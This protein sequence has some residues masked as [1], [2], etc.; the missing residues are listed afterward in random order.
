MRGEV[1]MGPP[2]S[3]SHHGWTY[4]AEGRSPVSSP[5]SACPSRQDMSSTHSHSYTRR[6]KG[7]GDQLHMFRHLNMPI[8]R[9]WDGRSR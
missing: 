5:Y 6:R 4:H 1:L 3:G 8:T 7:P 9:S 2:R